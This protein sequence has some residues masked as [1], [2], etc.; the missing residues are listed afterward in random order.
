MDKLTCMNAFT[1]VVDTGGFSAAGRKLGISKTLISK[2]VAPIEEDLGVLLLQRTTRKVSATDIGRAYY[3]R[4]MPLLAEVNEVEAMVRLTNVTPSGTLVVS[5]PTSFSEIH[6]MPV[7]AGFVAQYPEVNI[8]LKLT[9]RF[10]DIVDENV[11]I[12]VRI[13]K[14]DDSSLI[15]RKILQI[16][17]VGCASNEYLKKSSAINHPYDLIQHQCIVDSNYKN[18]RHWSFHLAGKVITAN[19]NVFLSVNSVR[20]V[21]ELVLSNSGIAICPLFAVHD[22]IKSG[23]LKVLLENYQL[24]QLALYAVYSHRRYL[25]AKNRLF[26]DFLVNHFATHSNGLQSSNSIL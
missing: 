25:S 21:K 2:Y 8:D 20:A 11:D 6:L 24:P 16:D 3:E 10:V 9:D 26:I 17:T 7:L 12:A 18:G 14:L 13:G 23:R 19:V 1:N 15:A 22:D 5:A 4:C